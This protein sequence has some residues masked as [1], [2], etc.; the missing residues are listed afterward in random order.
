MVLCFM[1]KIKNRTT[2]TITTAT[3]WMT[4]SVVNVQRQEERRN[5]GGGLSNIH[6]IGTSFGGRAFAFRLLL[7][8]FSRTVLSGA[9]FL[10]V[11]ALLAR[12]HVGVLFRFLFLLRFLLLRWFR[13]AVAAGTFCF[14]LGFDK[15]EER[16][17]GGLSA[18]AS[19]RFWLTTKPRATYL[20]AESRTR[21]AGTVCSHRTDR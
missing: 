14:V 11:L 21:T 17:S 19:G 9:R 20:A 13:F 10:P 7:G 6:L 8:R 4:Q 3:Q 12:F 5:E 2:T 18:N 16:S 15:R 1:R